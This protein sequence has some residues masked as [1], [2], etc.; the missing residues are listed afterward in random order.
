M[1]L[2]MEV[3]SLALKASIISPHHLTKNLTFLA[4]DYFERS[5]FLIGILWIT[6]KT[7]TCLF[8]GQLEF[9]LNLSA[10]F[11]CFIFFFPYWGNISL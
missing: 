6:G 3:L 2:K 4:K 1:V 7:K 5:H 11:P 8:I 9:F 10:D